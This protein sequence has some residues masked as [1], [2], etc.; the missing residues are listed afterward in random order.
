MSERSWVLIMPQSSSP[1]PV[2]LEPATA[3]E[4]MSVAATSEQVSTLSLEE[5]VNEQDESFRGSF[6]RFAEAYRREQPDLTESDY[7]QIDQLFYTLIDTLD[8][9]RVS[10]LFREFKT[11]SAANWATLLAGAWQILGAAGL[12]WHLVPAQTCI[13]LFWQAAKVGQNPE[14]YPII[15]SSRGAKDA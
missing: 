4:N 3:L 2:D 13:D 7:Q 15:F 11:Q 14:I 1:P 12:E 5:L 10:Q 6:G 8:P 9:S